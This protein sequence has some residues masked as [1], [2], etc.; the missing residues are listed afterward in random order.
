MKLRLI[1]LSAALAL[2]PLASSAKDPVIQIVP[3]PERI[4]LQ[5]GSFKAV[6]AGVNCDA[7]FD[8]RSRA[9]MQDFA[10][11]LSL[12]AGKVSSFAVPSSARAG[13]GA[14]SASKRPMPRAKRPNAHFLLMIH[15]STLQ[16]Y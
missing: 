10:A 13:P 7:A 8:E 11:R 2:L 3:Q 14:S 12:T 9:A 15:L 1:I 5:K 4:E 6:G 16:C